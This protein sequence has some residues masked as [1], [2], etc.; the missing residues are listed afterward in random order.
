MGWLKDLADPETNRVSRLYIIWIWLQ[1]QQ[2]TVE[3]PA[4]TAQAA[5]KEIE[6]AHSGFSLIELVCAA[7]AQTQTKTK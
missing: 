5:C 2:D 3:Q 6:N 7:K 4:E 1:K